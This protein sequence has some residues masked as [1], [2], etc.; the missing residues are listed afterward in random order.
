MVNMS[1]VTNTVKSTCISIQASL[2]S[3]GKTFHTAF[4][5]H[6]VLSRGTNFVKLGD[7]I[8]LYFGEKHTCVWWLFALVRRW[9]PI[10]WRRLLISAVHCDRVTPDRCWHQMWTGCSTSVLTGWTSE[11]NWNDW[12]NHHVT[13]IT[14]LFMLS[15][16]CWSR[17][18]ELLF[19]MQV[20]AKMESRMTRGLRRSECFR[21]ITP[22][23]SV[24]VSAELKIPHNNVE[25]LENAFLSCF[26]PNY[27]HLHHWRRA[28]SLI[29]DKLSQS[30]HCLLT[31]IYFIKDVMQDWV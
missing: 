13:A 16:T 10:M 11:E 18:G 1:D 27:Q 3:V 24:S 26:C 21:T 9:D 20:P 25:M 6:H 8:F 23:S 22:L 31:C 5:N 29:R 4:K 30:R 17:P 2:S 7:K 14:S 28:S 19:S 12:D 15:C